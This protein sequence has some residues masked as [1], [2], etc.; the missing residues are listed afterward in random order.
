MAFWKNK[1]L[2]DKELAEG[3]SKGDEAC[4]EALFKRYYV[5][6]RKFI[7]R[8]IEDDLQAAEDLAQEIFIRLWDRRYSIDSEKS[9]K[10]WLI[11]SARNSAFNWLKTQA[12]KPEAVVLGID[13]D[14]AISQDQDM[15]SIYLRQLGSEIDRAINDLPDKRR[16]VFRMS[17]FDHLP[18]EEIAARLGLS[19]RT[20]EK[21]IEL[22]LKNLR[23]GNLS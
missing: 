4:F 20:V 10:N 7:S 21:H 12:R 1:T 6:V 22:A 17:R 3:I 8:F 16:T 19:V 23:K 2:S 13:E 5:I 11:V 15:G 9:I 14:S 18:N